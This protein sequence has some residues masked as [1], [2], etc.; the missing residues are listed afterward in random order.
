MRSDEVESAWR[1]VDPILHAWRKPGAVPLH[2]YEAGTWGPS[3]A[4]QLF[5]D[6]RAWRRPQG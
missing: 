4:E 3:Q 5:E 2:A 1:H 6:G